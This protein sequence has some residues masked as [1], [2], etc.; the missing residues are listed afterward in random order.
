LIPTT[1]SEQADRLLLMGMRRNALRVLF[2][3]DAQALDIMARA[4]GVSQQRLMGPRG[5]APAWSPQPARGNMSASTPAEFDVVVV[6]AGISGIAAAHYLQR[7]CPEHS[8]PFSSSRDG[9]QNYLLDLFAMKLSPLRDG[10]LRFARADEPL[11]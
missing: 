8:W 7:E 4:L 3:P 6:G 2:G 9:H 1:A 5:A 11:R 10:A